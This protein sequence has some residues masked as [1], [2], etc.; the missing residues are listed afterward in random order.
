MYTASHLEAVL[1]CQVACSAGM[2][3]VR[4]CQAPKPP[5]Q[6]ES[7]LI[8]TDYIQDSREATASFNMEMNMSSPPLPDIVTNV[9]S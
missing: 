5:A 9:A 4:E 6:Y 2:E 8:A 1:I 3:Y 7:S